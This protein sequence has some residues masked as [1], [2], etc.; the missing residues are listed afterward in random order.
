MKIDLRKVIKNLDGTG[1][2][3]SQEYLVV[4]TTNNIMNDAEGKPVVV[5]ITDP[6]KALTLKAIC[7]NILFY[8]HA[9]EKND[10]DKKAKKFELGMK[11]LHTKK[12]INLKA[13][14]ITTIKELVKIRYQ[15]LIYGQICNILEGV[16]TDMVDAIDDEDTVTPVTENAS[17]N[18]TVEPILEVVKDVPSITPTDTEIKA[19]Q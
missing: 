10:G 8:D 19:E 5:T 11:I 7:K 3:T 18:N 17:T 15:T 6:K 12:E 1:M 13:E 14:E 16:E 2:G 9:D 4:D